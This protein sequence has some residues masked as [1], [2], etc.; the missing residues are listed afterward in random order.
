MSR[1]STQRVLSGQAWDDYCDSLKAAGHIIDA[2]G[3]LP[4]EQDRI[5]WYRFLTRLT[6]NGLERFVENSEPERPRLRDAPW[7]QSINFQ[8]PDQDHLLAEFVDGT[9]AYRITGERGTAPYFVMA[10]WTAATPADPGHQNWAGRG[11]EGL[12]ELNPAMLRTTGFLQSSAISYD[13]QGRFEVVVSQKRPTGGA[14]WLEITPDCVGL[15]IRVVYHRR[16]QESAPTF[17][18]ERVDGAAPVPLT[19]THLSGALAK[20]G[21]LVL[22][23]G[24]LVRSWFQ[25]TLSKSPNQIR[26]S[27]ALYLSNGGVP[28]RHHGFGM[29]E[30]AAGEALV[31]RFVPPACDYWIFQLCNIWQENL[32]NY[33]E[34]QG[35]LSQYRCHTETDGSVMVVIAD[36]DPRVG[37]NWVDSAGHPH[38][39]MSLRIILTMAP[40]PAVVVHRVALDH[41]QRDGFAALTVKTECPRGVADLAS[42]SV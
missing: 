24:E 33:E 34:G 25:D 39:G 20:A 41:L 35:Y 1:E 16:E 40:P 32:D 6:R 19:A 12:K 14:D 42:D 4:T 9:H 31:L 18:I 23:Y 5:E 29:W 36:S 17:R 7:R 8:S 37:G 13:A 21:Q 10:A 38:G 3:D 27:Q 2:F 22:G 11:V 15:L 26:F 28:D 30:K